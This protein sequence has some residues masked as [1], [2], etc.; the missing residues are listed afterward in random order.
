MMIS[1]C[2]QYS[3]NK[4]GKFPCGVCQN[5]VAGI[6]CSAPCANAGCMQNSVVKGKLAKATDF[7]CMTCC[8]GN[9]AG[10]NT[11]KVMLAGCNLEVVDR[12]CYLGDMLDGGGA[13]FSTHQSEKWMEEVQR[14]TSSAHN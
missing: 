14:T 3:K 7:V 11:E 2:C 13:E 12:F 9:P 6:P 8:S 10:D 1:R 5:G 4:S